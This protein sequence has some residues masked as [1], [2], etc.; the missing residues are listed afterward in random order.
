MDKN[1]YIPPEESK[2]ALALRAA[3]EQS[4]KSQAALARATEVGPSLMWQWLNGKRPVPAYKAVRLAEALGNTRPNEIS[5][6]YSRMM[7]S[8]ESK[9]RFTANER[10]L[11]RDDPLVPG[12]KDA[13]AVFVDEADFYAIDGQ[14]PVLHPTG[15]RVAFPLSP[16]LAT[17][18]SRT[19]VP[20]FAILATDDAM[21]PTIGTGDLV[22]VDPHQTVIRDGAIYAFAA[23][24]VLRMRRLRARID[25]SIVVITDNPNKA[26][27][28]EE[29]VERKGI[30]VLGRCIHRVGSL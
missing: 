15:V 30:S 25:G 27:Y 26:T 8:D 24:S 5:E 10:D 4:G 13:A 28:P 9:A 2:F 12:G 23:G 20:M 6:A 7:W 3:F 29:V 18:V 19:D 11:V 21:S 17:H 1:E 22:L 14:E 16:D